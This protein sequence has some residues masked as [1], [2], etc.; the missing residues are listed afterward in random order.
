V[1]PRDIRLSLLLCV[2]LLAA[3]AAPNQYGS[4]NG[5]SGAIAPSVPA[6]PIHWSGVFSCTAHIDG[7]QPA[8][9]W[10]GI[11]FRQEG[12]RLSGLYTFTDNFKYRD[13]VVFSGSLTGQSAQLTVTA[14]RTN[15]S[16]N[17]TAEMSGSRSFLTGPMMSGMSQQPV[18]S[19]TLALPP[20]DHAPPAAGFSF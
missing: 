5:Q 8:I 2:P 17:F 10:R 7:R 3:C 4:G 1:I 20:H 9:I 13:S 16:P 14:V 12:D 15:G 6:K 18:R 11:P 19:C